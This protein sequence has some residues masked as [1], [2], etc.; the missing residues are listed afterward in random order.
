LDVAELN[1]DIIKKPFR[2][3][4]SDFYSGG[5]SGANVTVN[6]RIESGSIQI[7]E[8]VLLT[9]S[10]EYAQVKSKYYNY[11]FVYIDILS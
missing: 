6:G 4:I 2:M 9:P 7:G 3:A 1:K 8:N 10:N 5:F 11:I